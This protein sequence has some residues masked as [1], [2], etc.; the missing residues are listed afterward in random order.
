MPKKKKRSSQDTANDQSLLA[1]MKQLEDKEP[2][3]RPERSKMQQIW[4]AKELREK[5]EK[6]AALNPKIPKNKSKFPKRIVTPSTDDVHRMTQAHDQIQSTF[7]NILGDQEHGT[8]YGI[9]QDDAAEE[10]QADSGQ[11]SELETSHILSYKDKSTIQ[12]MLTILNPPTGRGYGDA[13]FALSPTVLEGL[14]RFKLSKIAKTV[15]I[16]KPNEFSVDELHEILT[17]C[18]NP[19]LR[20]LL[21]LRQFAEYYLRQQSIG[22]DEDDDATYAAAQVTPT[23]ISGKE[24]ALRELENQMKSSSLSGEEREQ[25]EE[26]ASELHRQLTELRRTFRRNQMTQSL[27]HCWDTFRTLPNVVQALRFKMMVEKK[28]EDENKEID[29]AKIKRASMDPEEKAKMDELF[30][31]DTTDEEDDVGPEPDSDSDASSGEESMMPPETSEPLPGIR[32]GRERSCGSLQSLKDELER[33]Q[34]EIRISGEAMSRVEHGSEEKQEHRLRYMELIHQRRELLNRI[35]GCGDGEAQTFR[36][37]EEAV[38]TPSNEVVTITGFSRSDGCVAPYIIRMSSGDEERAWS[39]ELRPRD[40]AEISSTQNRKIKAWNPDDNP[41]AEEEGMRDDGHLP[42]LKFYDETQGT[43][44]NIAPRTSAFYDHDNVPADCIAMYKSPPWIKQSIRAM[45]VRFVD[46]VSFNQTSEFLNPTPVNLIDTALKNNVRIPAKVVGLVTHSQ[47]NGHDATLIGLEGDNAYKVEITQNRVKR[48]I[49]LSKNNV[50]VPD[51]YKGSWYRPTK[52]YYAL[53]C[54]R[55]KDKKQEGNVFS[56]SID[57]EPVGTDSDAANTTRLSM[58]ICYRSA[59]QLIF[60]DEDIWNAEKRE[61]D[62]KRQSS[63]T[64]LEKL[65]DQPINEASIA[66][67]VNSLSRVLTDATA[68]GIYSVDSSGDP[69]KLKD[70]D[71]SRLYVRVAVDCMVSICRQNTDTIKC[72]LNQLARITAYIKL[73]NKEKGERIFISRLRQESYAPE[74]LCTLSDEEMAPHIFLGP[75]TDANAVDIFNRHLAE[76]MKTQ[77][78]HFAIRFYRTVNPGDQMIKE[79][80]GEMWSTI[81]HLVSLAPWID[82]QCRLKELGEDPSKIVYYKPSD[83]SGPECFKIDDIIQNKI[84]GD[85]R[86][87]EFTEFLDNIKRIYGPFEKF[88]TMK[89]R[90]DRPVYQGDKVQRNAVLA[91]FQ[92]VGLE[93]WRANDLPP[94]PQL[95]TEYERNFEGMWSMLTAKFGSELAIPPKIP[96]AII[97]PGLFGKMR[98][99]L[100]ACIARSRSIVIPE[101]H[102]HESWIETQA[103]WA[104]SGGDLRKPKPLSGGLG[105]RQDE[106]LRAR[107]TGEHVEELERREGSEREAAASDAEYEA[108]EPM[109]ADSDDEDSPSPDPIPTSVKK[110]V[111]ASPDTTSPRLNCVK[112]GKS[113]AHKRITFPYMEKSSISML[114]F[115]GRNCAER[116]THFE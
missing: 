15:G 66:F 91:L 98:A 87:P 94:V 55:L 85:T 52:L 95:L 64:K 71:H 48:V 9:L 105:G 109:M 19:E 76:E 110:S 16:Y 62:R 39:D 24:L 77:E 57:L 68:A 63:V 51:I 75:N 45:Y 53:Q 42:T 92:K 38:Y 2:A 65:L 41:E 104:Q 84:S 44:M 56:G 49:R 31:A 47:L 81:P 21:L 10:Y 59:T 33:I 113:C 86:P 54:Y 78:A 4:R 7:E 114:H 69:L 29:R 108:E 101:P 80:E 3:A 5:R 34:N 43:V 103:S 26:R 107:A 28:E 74:V 23:E 90:E 115:C 12:S 6:E 58:E 40:G 70:G 25:L 99:R 61:H 79:R 97:A 22:G 67:T 93:S 46:P 1:K 96:S 112:C 17:A 100:S 8:A 73:D 37:G 89:P 18:L 72:L 83:G 106:D 50:D 13:L 20:S 32:T 30:G 88:R 36:V 14:T 35:K 102:G 116:S 11:L 27:E 60:Q 111:A 82:Q